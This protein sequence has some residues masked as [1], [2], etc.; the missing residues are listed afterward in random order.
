MHLHSPLCL[1]LMISGGPS[2]FPNLSRFL[3]VKLNCRML[4]SLQK[5]RYG[6]LNVHGQSMY[7]RQVCRSKI[8]RKER[9][10]H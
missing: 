2:K 7:I 3:N 5:H 4:W 1:L 9:P 8:L 6:Q 10:H